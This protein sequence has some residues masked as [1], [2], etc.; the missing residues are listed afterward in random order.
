MHV[1]A[2]RFVGYSHAVSNYH[3]FKS[4]SMHYKC[5]L[6][7]RALNIAGLIQVAGMCL[8]LVAAGPVAGRHWGGPGWWALSRGEAPG[9]LAGCDG[10]PA[11][12]QGETKLMKCLGRGRS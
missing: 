4:I 12:G 2:T 6:T 3:T 10:D 8:A 5:T 1:C 11:Q 7:C 9:W